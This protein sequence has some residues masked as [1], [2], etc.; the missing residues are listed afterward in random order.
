MKTKLLTA[1]LLISLS[2]VS[3]ACPE[4][5]NQ[6]QHGKKHRQHVQ[7]MLNLTDDQQ[8]KFE[9]VTQQER[10]NREAL[11]QKNHQQTQAKLVKIL[12][13]E[14]MKILEENRPEKKK[15]KGPRLR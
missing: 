7:K 10:E 14:Q 5:N 9:A 2:A 15:R 4:G 11:M 3:M 8:K 13:P 1:T 12:S 6:R